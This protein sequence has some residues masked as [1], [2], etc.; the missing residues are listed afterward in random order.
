MVG[1]AGP[2]GCRG[3]FPIQGTS[4]GPRG[5]SAKFAPGV[6]RFQPKGAFF[7]SGAAV[8]EALN[9]EVTRLPYK[10]PITSEHF[11]RFRFGDS[12]GG[13]TWVITKGLNPGRKSVGRKTFQ[14]GATGGAASEPPS[15]LACGQRDKINPLV[16]PFF[17]KSS[18]LSLLVISIVLVLVGTLPVLSFPL[19]RSPPH[20]GRR[21]FKSRPPY[22]RRRWR[23]PGTAWPRLS[24]SND[25]GGR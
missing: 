15:L 1:T 21:K 20:C 25:A 13:R 7:S 24:S 12:F 17:I 19:A 14:K 4:C 16:E 6:L 5:G 22:G 2:F 10:W 9:R 8:S 18:R 3:S 23:N 11:E